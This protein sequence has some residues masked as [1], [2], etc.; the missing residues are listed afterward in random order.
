MKID[1]YALT[2]FQS[3]PAKFDLRILQHWTTRRKSAPLGF[4]GAFHSGL[5]EW[6]R[7]ASRQSML[8]AVKNAWPDSMPVDD[9]RT[10]Q[11][12]VDAL[13]S[14]VKEYPGETFQLV[15]GPD[16]P[17]V[18]VAFTL[19]TDMYL[20]CFE[21]GPIAGVWDPE[22]VPI[23]QNCGMALEP[24]EYGGIFDLLVE[25]N[26]Q[27]FVVDHKTTS[28]L[29][30]GFFNQFRPNN[31]MTGYVWGSSK[32]S[33]QRVGGALINAICVLKSSP[34]KF[35]RQVTTRTDHEIAEW[36]VS[37]HRTCENIQQCRR[38]GI[39]HMQ[40]VNCT[41][42]GKCEFHAVH[43]LPHPAQ[44]LA[45]LDQ[46]YIKDTWDYEGRDE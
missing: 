14:Y 5:A 4:G 24:I 11:K 17:L 8:L 16:G 21:C 6:Y 26:Q 7:T 37:V 30:A 1:N 45:I 38:T 23:C 42:Y 40:T 20:S 27:V 39:W 22:L 12:C 18:E 32:L 43:E 35:A 33:G 3:C 46:E 41:M 36:M 2:M 44:R 28:Q 31:Q 15:Q 13:L 9:Y 25:F 19:P 10:L 29:G 34:T